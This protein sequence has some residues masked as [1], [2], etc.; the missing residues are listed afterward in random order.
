[1]KIHCKDAEVEMDGADWE[2]LAEVTELYSG[3][4]LASLILDGLFQPIRQL[5]ATLHWIYNQGQSDL[6]FRNSA[7]VSNLSYYFI[8][9]ILWQL[10]FS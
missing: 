1:M 4:D 5:Q 6:L 8:F 9:K 10:S 7:F 2:K 3:S